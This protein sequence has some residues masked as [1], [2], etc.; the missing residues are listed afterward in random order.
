GE[1]AA[2]FVHRLATEAGVVGIPVSAFAAT[3]GR[4]AGLVRFAFCK[5]PEVLRDAV[6]R[7]SGVGRAPNAFR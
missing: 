2:A 3:P 7:L 4:Y 5:R 1:D 6:R